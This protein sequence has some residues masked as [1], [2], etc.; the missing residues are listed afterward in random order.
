MARVFVTGSSTGLGLMAGELLVEQGHRVVLHAGQ[1][2]ARRR[3]AP[4]AAA[5]REQV[6]WYRGGV[7]YLSPPT[8]T[9]KFF[10]YSMIFLRGSRSQL[11]R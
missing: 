4:R 3:A 5:G 11:V 6:N 1:C 7:S 10:S 8:A 2:G 9:A